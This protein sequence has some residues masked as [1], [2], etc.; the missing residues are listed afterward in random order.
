MQKAQIIVALDVPGL[1]ELNSTLGRLPDTLKICKVGLEAFCADGPSVVSAVVTSGRSVFLDLKLHDIPRT[2]ARAVQ[3]AS[4]HHASLLTVHAGG[5]RA[6]LKAAV[7]AAKDAGPHAPKLIA[8]TVLTSM[9]DADLASVGVTRTS[10][11]Q[12]MALGELAI[13]C[14]IDGLVCSP[15]EVS[16]LR[17]RLGPAPLLVTPGIRMPS[18]DAGDQKRTGTPAEAVRA[19]SNYL[20]IGRPILEAP[21]MAAAV[22]TIHA[23]I[24]SIS[25]D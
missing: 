16:A 10:R 25:I 19:G 24:D 23:D 17:Q 14:G 5:G 11:D 20:V 1:N 15:Q 4:R 9:D 22:Q 2:V 12:V 3:T 8:V 13:S 6:M 21:D 18:G 7:E